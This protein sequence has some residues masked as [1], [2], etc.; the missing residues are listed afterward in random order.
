[1]K[2]LDLSQMIAQLNNSNSNSL[3]MC[4]CSDCRGTFKVVDCPQEY[5]H[6]DGWEM[7]AYNEIY[8]PECSDGGCVD[9]FFSELLNDMQYN[10]T[11]WDQTDWTRAQKVAWQE[12]VFSHGFKWLDDNKV[13]GLDAKMF[14]LSEGMIIHVAD[15]SYFSNHLYLERVWFDVESSIR[16]EIVLPAKYMRG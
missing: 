11:K 14:F 4:K 13:D 5:G 9:F 1:M 7:P 10:N 3:D 6:H 8:C 16:E 12:Y 15:S 2:P